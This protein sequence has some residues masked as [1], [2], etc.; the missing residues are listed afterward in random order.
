MARPASTPLG[1]PCWADL[2]TS[3]PQRSQDFY[4]ELF[5]WTSESAGEDYGGYIN[6]SK[7]GLGMTAGAMQKDPQ[8]PG[9]DAWTIY[10]ATDDA[11]ATVDLAA[12]HGAQVILPAMDVM[13]L[14]TMAILLD[15]G[16]AAVGAWQAGLHEGFGAIGQAGAPSWFELHTRDYAGAVAFYTEVFGWDAHTASDTDDF[17]Y[18]TLGEG[19]TSR[20]G[21]MDSSAFL[22]EGV[23]ASWQVYFG[24]DDADAA[25]ARIIELGGAIVQPAEDTP[26]GRLAGA[27]D[28]TGAFFKI[29]Q[30]PQA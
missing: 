14:G 5:G 8:M 24:V 22:P 26:Y 12:E 6:F 2:A 21:I 17:K 18:T 13:E 15:P 3:D 9:P 7:D 11:K 23:G 20:A 25:S 28:A 16:Q 30:P 29:T 1:A 10:L 27:T 4:G 19:E